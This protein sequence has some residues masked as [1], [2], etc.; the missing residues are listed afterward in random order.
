MS[1][2]FLNTSPITDQNDL[3]RIAIENQINEYKNF[4]TSTDYKVLP[5]Y[6]LKSGENLVDIVN[7]RSVARQ[8]IRDNQ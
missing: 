6:E 8:F 7:M 4:L 1:A 3:N 2:K 5:Y